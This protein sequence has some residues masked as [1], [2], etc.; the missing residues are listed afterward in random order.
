MLLVATKV[1]VP[2][3]LEAGAAVDRLVWVPIPD[4]QSEEG[5]VSSEGKDD[6]ERESA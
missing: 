2:N 4:T 6:K 3:V 5:Y 1:I